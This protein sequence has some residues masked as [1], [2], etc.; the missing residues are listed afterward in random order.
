MRTTAIGAPGSQAAR[1][2]GVDTDSAAIALVCILLFL[3]LNPFLA[4]LLLSVISVF[5]RVPTVV[6]AVSASVAFALFF[7]FRDY[8][9]EWYFN[10]TDDVPNYI[11]LYESYYSQSVI[12]LLSNFI[13]APNGNEILWHLPW[14][15]LLNLSGASAET[16]VLVHYFVI[17]AALFAALATLSARHLAPLALTYFLLTPISLDLAAHIWRQE[18]ATSIFLAGLGLHLVKGSRAGKWLICAAPLVHVSFIFFA[19]IF[20]VSE[21]IRRNR[22]FD[23]KL[24]FSATL[25]VILTVI[26]LLARAAVFFLDSIGLARIMSYLE[27]YEIDVTRVYIVICLYAVPLLVSFYLLKN[28]DANYAMMVVC[29]SVFSIALALPGANSMYERLLMSA[30]PLWGLFIFRCLL[31]NFSARWYLPAMLC[32][33]ITGVTRLQ[34]VAGRGEGPGRFLAFGHAFDPFMGVAK[35]LTNL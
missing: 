34:F 8:G 18:L 33:F 10:S 35:M 16:F 28:D 5:R 19:L 23:N 30:L 15:V 6:F 2:S 7:F 21:I 25:L 1:F 12:D 17:F 20:F 22:G 24:K 32:I 3:V 13:D 27:G 31:F 29:F 4:L 11:Y 26:P 14:W 9:I